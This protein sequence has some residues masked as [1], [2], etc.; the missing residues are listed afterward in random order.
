MNGSKNGFPKKGDRVKWLD[1]GLNQSGF[2]VVTF[3]VDK[4]KTCNVRC[5][6]AIY[7]RFFFYDQ[8]VVLESNHS[9]T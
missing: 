3:V 4:D 2:G 9:K 7:P 8:V 1:T 5:E 6:G